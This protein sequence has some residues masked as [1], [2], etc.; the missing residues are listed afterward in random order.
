MDN[1]KYKIIYINGTELS[2]DNLLQK[3]FFNLQHHH[4]ACSVILTKSYNNTIEHYSI[5]DIT[6]SVIEKIENLDEV[7]EPSHQEAIKNHMNVIIAMNLFSQ[8]IR[9]TMRKSHLY[10]SVF[11]LWRNKIWQ[12]C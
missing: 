7:D 1:S 4:T 12:D 11:I 3:Y 8:L 6:N 5:C 10:L 9:Q 2:I